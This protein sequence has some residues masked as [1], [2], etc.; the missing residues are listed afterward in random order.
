MG[1]SSLITPPPPIRMVQCPQ[2]ARWRTYAKLPSM[3]MATT[4]P[5]IYP[6]VILTL[7]LTL[8]L[9]PWRSCGWWR[10]AWYS[11]ARLDITSW[12]LSMCVSTQRHYVVVAH[13]YMAPSELSKLTLDELKARKKSTWPTG[14]V[15]KKPD[16]KQ[17]RPF[18][19]H[20]D[21]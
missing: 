2:A 9:T 6:S 18:F 3:S 4:S 15:Q 7:F 14:S 13:E 21:W 10:R 16:Y 12:S 1:S 11:S 17:Y 8:T 20:V 5:D 19:L